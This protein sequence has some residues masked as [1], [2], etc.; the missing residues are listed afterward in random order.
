[1]KKI[2]LLLLALGCACLCGCGVVE[3]DTNAIDPMDIRVGDHAIFGSYEQPP[4][5]CRAN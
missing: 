3:E 2:L 4:Q 1:M 5:R